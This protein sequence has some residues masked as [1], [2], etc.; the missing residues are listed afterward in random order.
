MS[1]EHLTQSGQYLIENRSTGHI[2]SSW[3]EVLDTAYSLY[4]GFFDKDFFH[5][6]YIVREHITNPSSTPGDSPGNEEMD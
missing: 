6:L 5:H 4:E 3:I 2:K 1:L